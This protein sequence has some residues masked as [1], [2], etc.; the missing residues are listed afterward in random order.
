MLHCHNEISKILRHELPEL[1]LFQG[2]VDDILSAAEGSLVD[3]A[4]DWD[5]LDISSKRDFAMGIVW[6]RLRFLIEGIF[7][8]YDPPGCDYD[9]LKAWERRDAFNLILSRAED[10]KAAVTKMLEE[11][12][13]QERFV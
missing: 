8:A 5:V 1:L 7:S 2:K 11:H 6:S 3:F 10:I 12:E 13:Q 4:I 9:W